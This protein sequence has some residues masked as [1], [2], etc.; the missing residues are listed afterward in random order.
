MVNSHNTLF[1]TQNGSQNLTMVKNL[2]T[3][4]ALIEAWRVIVPAQVG[5]SQFCVGNDLCGDWI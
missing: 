2:F 1:I 4:K 3:A 5:V